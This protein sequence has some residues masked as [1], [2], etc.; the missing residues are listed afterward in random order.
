[1]C[2]S[3]EMKLLL[4]LEPGGVDI[5]A[6]NEEVAYQLASV[7]LICLG[8]R[9]DD[10]GRVQETGSLTPLGKGIV[11]REKLRKKPI[12][13]FLYLVFGPLWA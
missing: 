4:R 6:G 7:G 9:D 2:G 5:P 11:R 8:F 13:N 3:D 1:M 10:P 12:R